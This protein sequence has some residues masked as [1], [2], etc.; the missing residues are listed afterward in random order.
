MSKENESDFK[1][2]ISM[3]SDEKKEMYFQLPKSL[4]KYVNEKSRIS[5]SLEGTK[6]RLEEQLENRKKYVSLLEEYFKSMK[7]Y[8]K[9]PNSNILKSIVEQQKLKIEI[10]NTEIEITAQQN[11]FVDSYIYYKEDFMERYKEGGKNKK[12]VFKK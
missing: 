10:H 4:E 6:K 12:S 7:E 5:R 11:V 8:E 2:N 3:V 1:K 9:N